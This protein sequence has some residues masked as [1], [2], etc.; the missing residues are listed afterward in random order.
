MGQTETPT[1]RTAPAILTGAA[2]ILTAQGWS[3]EAGYEHQ[4]GMEPADCPLDL[5]AALAKAAGVDIHSHAATDPTGVHAGAVIALHR[6]VFGREESAWWSLHN[7][8]DW[9]D[10]PYRTAGQVIGALR[11]A[12]QAATGAEGPF[13][14]HPGS[15][16][17]DRPG[18]LVAECGH[19]VAGSEW[20]A[21]FRTCERCLNAESACK[22]DPEE[23]IDRYA[24]AVTH[25]LA[26][27]K[28]P[29]RL[30]RVGA[31]ISIVLPA[32]DACLNWSARAGWSIHGH[33]P[34]REQ[35]NTRYMRPLTPEPTQVATLTRAWLHGPDALASTR[36]DYGFLPVDELN[37]LLDQAANTD[38]GQENAR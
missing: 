13:Y 18:Y 19:S 25:A 11:G 24:A 4:R 33:G 36:T 1:L 34:G 10:A 23:P 2:D 17:P 26:L 8:T 7:L 37:N 31:G 21:G 3:R 28:I 9:Q 5:A 29:S 15:E 32:A 20:R 6:H 38:Q 35:T 16:V 30:P 22:P 12:A 14:P 27:A